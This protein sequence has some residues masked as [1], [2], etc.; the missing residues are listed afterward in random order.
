M[1][2]KARAQALIIAR[3]VNRSIGRAYRAAEEAMNADPAVQVEVCTSIEK[4]FRTKDASGC[5]DDV[6]DVSFILICDEWHDFVEFTCSGSFPAA[7]F[8][9]L[10]ADR[11]RAERE[12]Y[13]EPTIAAPG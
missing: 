10:I 7:H 9:R 13:S 5:L 6:P 1:T 8:R 3:Q 12:A 2:V 4:F 11:V